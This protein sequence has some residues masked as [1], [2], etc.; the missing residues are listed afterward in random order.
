M[1]YLYLKMGKLDKIQD[2]YLNNINI[3]SMKNIN[4]FFI[5]CAQ[6]KPEKNVWIVYYGN[7]AAKMFLLTLRK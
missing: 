3:E 2:E 6:K 4:I 7:A 1:A 5:F